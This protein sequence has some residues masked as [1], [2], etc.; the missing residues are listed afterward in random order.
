MMDMDGTD[1]GRRTRMVRPTDKQTRCDATRYFKLR[2]EAFWQATLP[3]L[4]YSFRYFCGTTHDM[5]LSAK[6]KT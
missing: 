3:S 2:C 4:K 5:R 6:K 1:N